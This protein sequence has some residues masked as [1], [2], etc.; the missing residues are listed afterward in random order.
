MANRKTRAERRAERI[1]QRAAME[2]Q[3]QAAKSSMVSTTSAKMK[4]SENGM[5]K[6]NKGTPASMD[7]CSES[8]QAKESAQ[9]KETMQVKEAAQ[10]I[11]MVPLMSIVTEEY[12]RALNM[13]NVS[14]IVK[15]F[16]PAKL[17]VLVVSHRV[18][19][20]YAIL[21]GQHRLAAL[22]NMGYTSANCIVLEGMTVQ[23]EADY[24]RRQNENKQ[25][26]RIVDTFNASIW[27]DEEESVKIYHIMGKY[28][29]R[30][31]KSGQPMCICAI[32]ALQLIIR[33]FGETVL[34]LVLQSISETWPHDTCILRR[35]MLAGLGEFWKRY[36]DV[37]TPQQFDARMQ[38]KFPVELHQELRRRTQGKATP[39][40]AFSKS[41][42]F[43]ACAVLVDAYNKGLRIGS[44]NRLKLEWDIT[45]DA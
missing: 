41:I 18:D 19:G 11:Q 22:R 12:Q 9:A 30:L 23:Q 24:F 16:D 38:T 5:T 45:E 31:G 44:K 4:E 36:A 14:G 10:Q 15:E 40:S 33:Q 35:E 28:G 8:E 26:L 17:G 7:R 34:E 42:R 20:T 1:R 32:G 37:I 13:K 3:A 29:F 39:S 27:A 6:Q 43:T 21:D 25:S 2:A